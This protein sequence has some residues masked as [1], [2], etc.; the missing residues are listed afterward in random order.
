MMIIWV[1]HIMR[2]DQRCFDIIL[3]FLDIPISYVNYLALNCNNF[4]KNYCKVK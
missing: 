2:I 1:I 3:W 4:I